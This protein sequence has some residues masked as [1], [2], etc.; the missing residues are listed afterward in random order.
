MVTSTGV[1]APILL[2]VVDAA[3]YIGIGR[4]L[5]YDLLA[6]GTIESIAIGRRRLVPVDALDA[7]VERLRAEEAR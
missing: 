5:L 2:S 4:S 3:R 1:A 7:Y 6:D